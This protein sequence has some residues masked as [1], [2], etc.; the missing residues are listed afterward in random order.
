MNRGSSLQGPNL[1]IY[2]SWGDSLIDVNRWANNENNG[3]QELSYY[4]PKKSS[5]LNIV[6]ERSNEEAIE[7]NSCEVFGCWNDISFA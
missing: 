3:F 4:L 1:S 5:L 2:R 7:F 6:E